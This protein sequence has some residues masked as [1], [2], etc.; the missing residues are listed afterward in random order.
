M[1]SRAPEPNENGEKII[2]VSKF[3]FFLIGGTNI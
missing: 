2:F 1:A 3:M